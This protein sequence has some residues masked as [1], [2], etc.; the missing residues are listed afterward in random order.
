MLEERESN[1]IR[2]EERE[3]EGRRM[4]EEGMKGWN[5]EK[6][7]GWDRRDLLEYKVKEL[8][9][10]EKLEDE[11][12]KAEQKKASEHRSLHLREKVFDYL[13]LEYLTPLEVRLSDDRRAGRLERSDS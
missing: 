8:E 1:V 3:R 4:R 7:E 12:I 13:G 11:A 9:A 2:A 6:V 10:E 5:V